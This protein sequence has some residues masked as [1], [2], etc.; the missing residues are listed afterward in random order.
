MKKYLVSLFVFILTVSCTQ[1]NV[2]IS[3]S[4][5]YNGH[6]GIK[7]KVDGVWLKPSTA[8]IYG[9]ASLTLDS[10]TNGEFMTISFH[11]S[12]T[13]S[14]S[15]F[16]AIRIKIVNFDHTMDLTGTVYDLKSEVNNE[17]FG[18]YI[19][20]SFDNPYQT[21]GSAN[22][23]LKILYHDVQK[24]IFGGTFWFDAIDSNGTNVKIREGQFD[25]NN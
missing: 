9:N 15:P 16:Q 6:G 12:Q 18:N 25:M 11:K 14:G 2:E 1:N 21:T 19:R 17:S 5:V 10:D 8:I 22:G 4:Y 24:R 3:D 20:G 23:Q 13:N 7:C